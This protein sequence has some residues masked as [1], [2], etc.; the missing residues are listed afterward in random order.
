[1]A[2]G[3]KIRGIR[4][5]KGFTQE[6]MAES[7]HI[8]RNAYS[9]IE[10]GVSDINESRLKQIADALNV[11]PNDIHNFED[12]KTIFFEHCNGAVGISNTTTQNINSNTK[13]LQHQ[14]EILELQLKNQQ[15]EIA[16]LQAEKEKAELEAMYWKM[17]NKQV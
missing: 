17:A 5:L 1:M 6:N 13:D 7:L 3:G 4:L 2:T 14:I 9:E 11:S 15:L 10:R 16:K 12:K 8:S